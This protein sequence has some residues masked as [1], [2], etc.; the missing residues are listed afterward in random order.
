MT[1]AGGVIHGARVTPRLSPCK[2][3]QEIRIIPTEV[4]QMGMG[5]KVGT[6]TSVDLTGG[7]ETPQLVPPKVELYGVL[8]NPSGRNKRTM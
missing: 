3:D 1:A 7:S 2:G 6:E 5:Q 4:G 8:Q